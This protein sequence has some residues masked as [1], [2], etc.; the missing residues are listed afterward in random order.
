MNRKICD[1]VNEKFIDMDE[2]HTL[3]SLFQPYKIDV[4]KTIGLWPETMQ[5]HLTQNT[6]R[7]KQ[8][9]KYLINIRDSFLLLIPPATAQ[10]NLLRH[11]VQEASLTARQTLM[12]SLLSGTR[13]CIGYNHKPIKQITSAWTF[14]SQ[15]EAYWVRGNFHVRG[16]EKLMTLMVRLGRRSVLP[17]KYWA[18]EGS[19]NSVFLCQYQ[20]FMP[21][22]NQVLSRDYVVDGSWG[23]DV[24]TRDPFFIGIGDAFILRSL[25]EDLFPLRLDVWDKKNNI[26]IHID[27]N[28]HSRYPNI[29]AP[30]FAAWTDVQFVSGQVRVKDISYGVVDGRLWLDHE[31]DSKI[32]PCILQNTLGA[33]VLHNL[34]GQPETRVKRLLCYLFFNDGTQ[35]LA[36]DLRPI[37]T[38]EWQLFN[39]TFTDQH[40]SI[41]AHYRITKTFTSSRTIYPLALE[42]KIQDE[43]FHVT[44]IDESTVTASQSVT[45]VEFLTTGVILSGSRKGSGFLQCTGYV[46]I[47]PQISYYLETLGFQ[48]VHELATIFIPKI[49]FMTKIGSV[50]LGLFYFLLILWVLGIITYIYRRKKN[51]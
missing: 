13:G 39:T 3:R 5:R 35:M 33:R 7:K 50:A 47:I 40:I 4:C 11:R 49:S 46:E 2:Y 24:N 19:D 10:L 6:D 21:S 25:G 34:F 26:D 8:I 15:Q 28:A 41:L 18:G 17:K 36:V 51:M 16:E 14:E 44:P 45:Q 30:G 37:D 9:L 32:S 43:I 22:L 48:N 27:M 31:L 38:K 1:L 20:L 29:Q 12:L 23:I 42:I